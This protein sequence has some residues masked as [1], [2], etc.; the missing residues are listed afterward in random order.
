MEAGEVGNV[1]KGTEGSLHFVSKA[2][3]GGY[4]DSASLDRWLGG[5]TL[6]YTESKSTRWFATVLW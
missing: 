5:I 4:A 1:T 3:E 6:S 2:N